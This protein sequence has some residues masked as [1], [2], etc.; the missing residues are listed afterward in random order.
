MQERERAHFSNFLVISKSINLLQKSR[1]SC[2]PYCENRPNSTTHTNFQAS[3]PPLSQY[4]RVEGGSTCSH[5]RCS[6]ARG[7]QRARSLSQGCWKGVGWDGKW[8]PNRVN[9]P[10]QSRIS[11]LLFLLIP[12]PTPPMDMEWREGGRTETEL[13]VLRLWQTAVASVLT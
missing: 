10:H 1:N 2:V 12:I 5:S 13:T 4:L 9:W 11:P 8:K 3:A 6:L 7:A